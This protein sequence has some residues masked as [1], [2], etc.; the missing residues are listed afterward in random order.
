MTSCRTT[1]LRTSTGSQ[2]LTTLE[3]QGLFTFWFDTLTLDGVPQEVRGIRATPSL[4]RVLRVAPLLGR[5]FTDAEGEIGNDQKIILSYAL[6]QR[7][8][9]GDPNVVGRPL[10]LAWNGGLYTIVGV[11]PPG[12]RFFDREYSGHAEAVQGIQFWIPLAFTPEQKS[13]RARTRY[14]FFHVGRLRPG[15][16][17]EQTQ[18]QLDVLHAA[19]VK[20]FPQFQLCRA[21]HV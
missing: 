6:W 14:G 9:G 2:A 17:V 18:A 12:F 4:F 3:E 16:T 5:T 11:M 10:R 20:R 7:L 19:T 13:D 8:F 15:A 1:R 21:R